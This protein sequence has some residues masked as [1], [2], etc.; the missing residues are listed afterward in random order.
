MR[1]A[2]IAVSALV[3]TAWGFYFDPLMVHLGLLEWNPVGGYYGTP[4]LNLF[5]WLISL[6]GNH[7]WCLSQTP[8]WWAARFDLWDFLAG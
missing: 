1:L 2:F 5:G 4:W 8:A 6:R 7:I 3:F